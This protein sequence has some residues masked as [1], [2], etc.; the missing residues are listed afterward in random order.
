MQQEARAA[1]P[2]PGAQLPAPGRHGES[3]RGFTALTTRISTVMGSSDSLFR[4]FS[5]CR[6]KKGRVQACH[7][8]TNC[9]G[10]GIKPLPPCQCQALTPAPRVLTQLGAGRALGQ[11]AN[12]GLPQETRC[13][14][15]ASPVRHRADGRDTGPALAPCRSPARQH[16]A[17]TGLGAALTQR[18]KS[19]AAGARG[20]QREP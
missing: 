10:N 2:A 13:L 17:G 3:R 6:D 5:S 11:A 1:H 18:S 9:D 20:P 16:Q 19:L 15:P 12:L 7:R 8:A 14:V 4:L